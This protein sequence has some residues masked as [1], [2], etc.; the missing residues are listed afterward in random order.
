MR[1]T[2]VEILAAAGIDAEGAAS[3]AAAAEM[4]QQLAPAVALVD[5]RLPDA[6]GVELGALLKHR[7]TDLAVLLVTGYASLDNAIAAVWELDGFLTKPVPPAE[8]VR[9]V[10]A[11]LDTTRLR[12]ENR[13]R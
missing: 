6:N 7:D 2:L 5:Q 4:Q 11:A 12:S 8:L 1:E 9:V 3:A 10:R 13:S